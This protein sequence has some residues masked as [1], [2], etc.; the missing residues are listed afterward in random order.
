MGTVDD[1]LATLRSSDRDA[2]ERVRQVVV[3]AIP[4]TT[5]GTSYGLA[6]LLLD[7]RPL[8]GF[9]AAR[10]HLSLFPFSPAVVAAV[11]DQLTG[12]SVSKGTVR[13]SAGHPLPDHV[14]VTMARLRGEEIRLP[15]GS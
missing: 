7:G 4:G 6:A 9:R 1:Y 5:Q 3:G 10:D 14:L 12:F 8:L 2:L 11:A 15:K 13:F